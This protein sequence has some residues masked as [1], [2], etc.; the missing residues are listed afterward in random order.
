MASSFLLQN[1]I[2]Q[3]SAAVYFIFSNLLISLILPVSY[4]VS[5]Q[6]PHFEQNSAHILYQGDAVLNPDG[7]IDFN[8]QDYLCRVGLITYAER[9][10]L[11]D[12]NSGS[13]SDFN[14]HFSFFIDTLKQPTYGHG[15]AFFMAPD[16]FHIPPNSNGGFLGLFN[17]T[18][19]DSPANQMI[20]VEFDSF[21][22]PEWDPSIQHV[23]I[24]N[25]SI[26]SAVYAPWNASLHTGDTADAWI[27]YNS[28]TKNLSVFWSYSFEPD[29]AKNSSLSLKIDLAKVL[30]EWVTIGFS[31]ATGIYVERHV[32]QSW[33]F[34]S[35]LESETSPGTNAMVTKLIVGLTVPI[36]VLIVGGTIISS[37]YWR[38]RRMKEE[39]PEAEGLTS[40]NDELEK[41]AGPRRFTYIEL[42]SATNN[43]SKDRKLGEGGFGGVYKGHLVDLGMAIAVKRISRGSKQGKT[44]YITEVKV[45]SRLRHRNLVQLIGWCHDEGEF[46]LVYE[47]MPNG[48]LDSHLF[49]KGEPLSWPVRHKVALGLAFGLLYLHEEWEQCVVHRDIKPSNIMLDS[50]F[51]VKLGDFGLARLMN[52]ELG[53][54]TTVLAGTWGYMAPEYISTRKASKE[55]D[56]YSFGVVAL[57]IA[58]GKR[59]GNGWSVESQKGLVEWAW[60]HYGKGELLLIVDERLQMAYDGNQAEC[61]MIVGL[62]CV[63]PDYRKRP[64]IR[65]AIQ[66]LK[67][68]AIMPSLPQKM[69]VVAYNVPNKSTTSSKASFT[70][71][72]LESGR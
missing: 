35:N 55:S 61:L 68:E 39:K 63:H 3:R 13:L 4:S 51:N 27:I 60:D 44:Q 8:K 72:V 19:F 53:A 45:I 29:Y 49:G 2:I 23:G 20:V 9:V 42:A 70:T 46:L 48:S 34:S 65:Q 16:G 43:F 54:E 32:L 64:S 36:G 11:W 71:T 7:A 30:S 25:N 22:N 69:P 50:S 38:Q 18:T 33:E 17:T 26:K 37:F 1:S 41:G 58:T 31:A 57:E 66:V 62:W 6:F 28:T 52:H 47:F 67:F 56:V 21:P 40:F 12:S 10:Q 24:N 14:T 15:L 5:F 59:P